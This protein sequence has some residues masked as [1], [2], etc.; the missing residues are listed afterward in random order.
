MECCFLALLKATQADTRPRRPHP[1]QTTKEAVKTDLMYFD[2]DCACCRA[3]GGL[4]APMLWVSDQG[5]LTY[6]A[7]G[8]C[9]RRCDPPPYCCCN[10]ASNTQAFQ[11][12]E[13]IASVLPESFELLLSSLASKPRL[14][15]IPAQRISPLGPSEARDVAVRRCSWCAGRRRALS[16]RPPEHGAPGG[17]ADAKRHTCKT[18]SF[19]VQMSRYLC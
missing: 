16:H 7:A 13:G 10:P 5:A 17:L 3:A 19:H 1:Y 14:H 8:R 4:D 18:R 11:C 2:L 6:L 15:H 12:L 9:P